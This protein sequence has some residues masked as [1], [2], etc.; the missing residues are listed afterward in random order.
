[1]AGL[2]QNQSV[3]N[4]RKG[5]LVTFLR[6][7]AERRRQERSRGSVVRGEP[8]LVGFVPRGAG[9]HETDESRRRGGLCARGSNQNGE[10]KLRFKDAPVAPVV[11]RSVGRLSRR[12]GKYNYT[13]AGRWRIIVDAR[14]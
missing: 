13:K 7:V 11:P 12:R 6:A 10:I 9:E 14:S 4:H 2:H 1:M 5:S 3:E 8:S